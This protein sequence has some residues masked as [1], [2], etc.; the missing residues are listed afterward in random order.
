MLL[1]SDALGTECS[2]LGLLLQWDALSKHRCPSCL[3]LIQQASNM[4]SCVSG[5]ACRLLELEI[6]GYRRNLVLLSVQ[7]QMPLKL[8]A[9]GTGYRMH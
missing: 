5:P 6:I 3:M 1:N 4:C 8:D 7:A 2:Y 9:V